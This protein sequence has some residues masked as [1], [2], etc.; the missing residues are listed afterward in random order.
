MPTCDIPLTATITETITE[1]YSYNP[2]DGKFYKDGQKYEAITV[3]ECNLMFS[4]SPD[5]IKREGVKVK[6]FYGFK[7]V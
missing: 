7:A 5:E 3:K 1:T 2:E 6:S 4:R